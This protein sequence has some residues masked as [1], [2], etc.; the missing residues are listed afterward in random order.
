[1]PGLT[2]RKRADMNYDPPRP[3]RGIQLLDAPKNVTVSTTVVED[4]IAAGWITAEGS[5]TVT[6][7][8][9]PPHDKDR[10]G[11][12]HSFR[13]ADALVFHT[14]DG[15]VRYSVVHNPDKYADHEAATHPDQVKKLKADDTTTITDDIYAAGATRVDHFYNLVKEG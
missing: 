11:T 1:M 3:L 10:P 13:Q 7:P 4:G 12:A 15:D 6:R 8:G 5:R 9:G 14:L 2:I